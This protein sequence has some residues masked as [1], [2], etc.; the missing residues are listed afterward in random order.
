MLV[1]RSRPQLWTLGHLWP[2]SVKETINQALIGIKDQ[3]IKEL[4]GGRRSAKRSKDG[5]LT[6][7]RIYRRD[8]KHGLVPKAISLLTVPK[9]ALPTWMS[10]FLDAALPVQRE[11]LCIS[12]A[13]SQE[14]RHLGIGSP[15]GSLRTLPLATL[16]GKSLVT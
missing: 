1:T 8:T 3:L 4:S 2:C 15:E 5:K 6:A 12:E 14:L 7:P 10:A 11:F 16:V 13:W 9:G